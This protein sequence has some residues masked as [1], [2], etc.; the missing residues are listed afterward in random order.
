MPP[1]ADSMSVG[2]RFAT[3]ISYVINPLI[4]PPF[5]FGLVLWHFGASG[6]EMSSAVGIGLVFFFLIPL[7]YMVGMVRRGKATTLEVR[8]RD[9]RTGPF[10][11]GIASY[12]I[13]CGLLWITLQTA[14]PF[15]LTLA[16]IYP[17]N[18]AFVGLIN[19]RWKISVHATSIAG[20]VVALL[21]I[22]WAAGG[23]QISGV[24]TM[25]STAPLLVFVPLVMWARVRSGA[26]TMAQVIGGAAFGSS[27]TFVQL[28]L[29][30]NAFGFA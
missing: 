28:I 11:F 30:M 29:A 5:Q 21:F 12:V 16:A 17:V 19:L 2:Y 14:R 18:T 1:H 6:Q 7:A 10:L 8:R 3:F 9:R 23:P 13:G 27:I 26:H 25:A 4:L 24:L 15:V 22:A 20:F